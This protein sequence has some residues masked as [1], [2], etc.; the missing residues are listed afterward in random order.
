MYHR[1]LHDSVMLR[2][3]PQY[4]ERT[5]LAMEVLFN[6]EQ[7]TV[8]FP[9]KLLDDTRSFLADVLFNT[10]PP[11]L[12]Q[13]IV[14]YAHKCPRI[15][16][17]VHPSSFWWALLVTDGE[18]VGLSEGTLRYVPNSRI[19]FPTTVFYSRLEYDEELL[20][21]K[22]LVFN[23]SVAWIET[24]DYFRHVSVQLPESVQNREKARQHNMLACK[25]FLSHL[26]TFLVFEKISRFE[27]CKAMCTHS[28]QCVK[29]L[30]AILNRTYC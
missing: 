27:F 22:E 5:S 14:A 4:Y 25:A 1:F 15:S 10:L 19:P 9:K 30:M 12:L 16:F 24:A 28:P 26:E 3:A 7:Q 6:K 17:V 18:H 8:W 20:Y 13:L 2:K 11:P 21:G 23:G 29:Q